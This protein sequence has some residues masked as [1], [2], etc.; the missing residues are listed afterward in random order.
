MGGGRRHFLPINETD[1]EDAYAINETIPYG[2]RIDGRNLIK[3]WREDMDC[4]YEYKKDCDKKGRFIHNAAEVKD[5]LKDVTKV[6]RILGLFIM[7]LQ[8][9]WES[10]YLNAHHLISAMGVRSVID[11][12]DLYCSIHFF[13]DTILHHI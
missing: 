12:N 7:I 9:L 2:K 1:S 3:E 11:G 13:I 5:L 6:D 4:R 10:L 8:S